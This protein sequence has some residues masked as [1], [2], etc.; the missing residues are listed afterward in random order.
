MIEDLRCGHIIPLVLL[1]FI[2]FILE[3]YTKITE[4]GIGNWKIIHKYKITWRSFE[5][6]DNIMHVYL[7]IEILGKKRACCNHPGISGGRIL[8][9]MLLHLL[10]HVQFIIVVGHH[11]RRE[12]HLPLM[13]KL[14]R[15]EGKLPN[16][17]LWIWK[18]SSRCLLFP[19]HLVGQSSLCTTRAKLQ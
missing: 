16:N 6:E 19:F 5:F 10:H 11:F 4:N 14:R 7:D 12:V 17:L 9:R 13:A 2:D 18:A 15:N 8:G 3:K 1:H